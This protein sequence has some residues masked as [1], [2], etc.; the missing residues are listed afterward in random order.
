MEPM[1]PRHGSRAGYLAHRKDDE[2]PCDACLKASSRT[3]KEYRWRTKGGTRPIMVSAEEA[4]AVFAEAER[5]GITAHTLAE[6]AGLTS[7]YLTH[8]KDG[9]ADRPCAKVRRDT[10]Q[11][12]KDALENPELASGLVDGDL[13][14]RRLRSLQRQGWNLKTLNTMCDVDLYAGK[15]RKTERV[16]RKVAAAVRDLVEQIGDRTGPST[17][18][19]ARAARMEWPV[20]AAWDDPGTL[21]WGPEGPTPIDRPKRRDRPLYKAHNSNEDL[22]A[23]WD[24]MNRLGMSIHE[25]A[26]KLGVTVA[27]IRKAQERAGKDAA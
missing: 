7:S 11:R 18:G 15:W 8:L 19:A 22:L 20:L 23:E 5:R 2:D 14:R 3:A 16:T 4:K 10:V 9:R 21:A 24:H 27:A 6:A 17:I 13:T 12:L 1:D 25:A 26:T